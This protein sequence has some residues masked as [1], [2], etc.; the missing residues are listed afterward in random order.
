MQKK[1]N[2]TQ[3]RQNQMPHKSNRKKTTTNPGKKRSRKSNPTEKKHTY[4]EL[5]AEWWRQAVVDKCV[6]TT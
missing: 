3:E 5:M 2:K 4:N 1:L 6:M